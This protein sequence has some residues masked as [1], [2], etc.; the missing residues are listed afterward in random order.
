MAKS[1]YQVVKDALQ[2][3]KDRDKYAYFYGA[4][5]QKLTKSVMDA[6]WNAEPDY[7]KKYNAAEKE[8]IY[9]NSLNKIG[10]DCS[11]FVT[12]V[13]GE[14]GYSIGI[15]NKRTKETSLNEGVA[16]QFLFTTFHGAGRHI[17]L[18]V[19]W[20]FTMDMGNESTDYQV[21][22]HRDSV[23]LLNM[24]DIQWEHSFQTAA[25]NYDYSYA[26]DPNNVT[27]EKPTPVFPDPEPVVPIKPIDPITPIKLD[28]VKAVTA[29]NVRE[30]ASALATKVVF[31]R[32]DGKGARSALVQGE[33]VRVIGQKNGWYQ[34]EITG[35]SE[36]WRPYAN[37]KYFEAAVLNIPI[38]QATTKLNVRTG[39]G[40]AYSYCS[41]D[42]NDGRLVRHVLFKGEEA[43]VIKEVNGWCQLE[44]VGEKLVWRPWAASKYLVLDR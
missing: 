23:R 28:A 33:V 20:G 32:N 12:R 35:A 19:G 40:N 14:T 10:L 5:G 13:T 18:D 27:P 7:F 8:Q 11:G 9:R 6:L 43:P 29:V 21:Q 41:F 15:Y 30:D 22:M 38:A 2:M 3:Y 36:V 37:S 44:I 4:K 39:P 31:D 26:F 16:G 42:R 17:G 1:W 24:G 34:L 25:V